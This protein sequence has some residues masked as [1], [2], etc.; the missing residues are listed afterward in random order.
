MTTSPPFAFA[1]LLA[2]IEGC[3]GGHPSAPHATRLK[4]DDLSLTCWRA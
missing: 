2:R 3:C 1:E 4:V